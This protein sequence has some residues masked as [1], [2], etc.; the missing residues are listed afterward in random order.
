MDPFFGCCLHHIRSRR[1]KILIAREVEGM[2]WI[3]AEAVKYGRLKQ[4][5]A[6]A[7]GRSCFDDRK[8]DAEKL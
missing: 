4:V 3:R 7:F 5:V 2:E 8:T 6:K 1:C